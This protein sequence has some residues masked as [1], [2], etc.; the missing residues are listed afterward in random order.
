MK[1]FNLMFLM[2]IFVVLVLGGVVGTSVAQEQQNNVIDLSNIDNPIGKINGQNPDAFSAQAGTSI[3]SDFIEYDFDFGKT[4]ITLYCNG[5]KQDNLYAHYNESTGKIDFGATLDWLDENEKTNCYYELESTDDL[6][7]LI[8]IRDRNYNETLILQLAENPELNISLPE[9]DEFEYP[10]YYNYE[11]LVGGGEKRHLYSLEGICDK[12]YS[13]CSW[14]RVN[15]KMTRI[16]FTTERN[17]E[18]KS[19][20][21]VSGC[22]TISVAGSYQQNASYSGF[23]SDCIVIATDNVNFSG[24]GYTMVSTVSAADGIRVNTD[25]DN[26]NITNVDI[27]LATNAY[28]VWKYSGSN[29]TITNSYLH[30]LSRGIRSYGVNDRIDNV[31]TYQTYG[32]GYQTSTGHSN[33]YVTNSEFNSCYTLYCMYFAQGDYT[34]SRFENITMD[35][36]S[37]TATMFLTNYMGGSNF[38][39]IHVT[40]AYNDILYTRDGTTSAPPS[41]NFYDSSFSRHSTGYAT[42]DEDVINGYDAAKRVNLALY[43]TTGINPDR[44]NVYANDV[45]N[46]Y[47]EYQ[48][49]VNDTNGNPIENE[50]VSIYVYNQTVG[51]GL[52]TN[53]YLNT[54]ITSW[55]TDTVDWS[56]WGPLGYNSV[57]HYDID[58]TGDSIPGTLQ[59]DPAVDV[60]VGQPYLI[61]LNNSEFSEAS[62]SDY[63]MNLSLGNYNAHRYNEGLGRYYNDTYIALPTNTDNLKFNASTGTFNDWIELAYVEVYNVTTSLYTTATT[64]ASGGISIYLPSVYMKGTDR[65]FFNQYYGNL[66][67]GAEF[68]SSINVKD[69]LFVSDNFEIAADITIPLI[70][71]ESGTTASGTTGENLIVANITASDVSRGIKNITANIYN[72]SGLYSS[73]TNA[74]ISLIYTF[75]SLPEGTYYLNA[76]TYDYGFNSNSTETRTIVIT[77][78]D[79]G[80]ELISPSASFNISQNKFFNVTVNVSCSVMNCS[81]INVSLDRSTS[82]GTDYQEVTY[83]YV[84]GNLQFYADQWEGGAN[85]GEFDITCTG[86]DSNCSFTDLNGLHSTTEINNGIACNDAATGTGFLMYTATSVHTRFSANPPHA[87]NADN[88]ICVRYSGGWQYDSNTDWHSFTPVSTDTL[89]AD[90]SYTSDTITAK[91]DYVVGLV[92]TPIPLSTGDPFYTNESNPRNISLNKDESEVVTFWVNA[93]GSEAEYANL[94]VQVNKTTNQGIGNLTSFWDV[95][96]DANPPAISNIAF[97]PNLSDDIDPGTKVT[98]NVTLTDS[99]TLVNTAILQYHNGTGWNNET[100]V[101]IGSNIYQANITTVSIDANYTFN[102][103]ANDS[104]NNFNNSINQ[105]FNSTWDCTWSITSAGLT[106]SDA[107]GSFEDKVIGNITINNTGDVEY[108]D[109]N[110]SVSFDADGYVGFSGSY[111]ASTTWPSSLT[112]MQFYP[113]SPIVIAAGG[114]QIMIVNASFP[115]VSTPLE[116]TVTI[117]VVGDITDSV[118]LY[119][120]RT[121][122]VEMTV[123]KAGPYL[124]QSL[125]TSSQTVYLTN[126]TLALNSSLVN[127]GGDSTSNNSAYNASYDWNLPSDFLTSN[128]SELFFTNISNNSKIYSAIDVDF[129]SANLPSLSS[130]IYSINLSSNA[131]NLSGDLIVHAGNLTTLSDS[132]NITLLC[133]EPSDGIYVADCGTIDGDYA[134][135]TTGGSSGGGGGGGGSEDPREFSAA[136]FELLRGEEQK[137]VLTLENKLNTSRTDVEISVS[138]ANSQY[139]KILTP[140]IDEIKPFSS[141]DVIV[142]ITAPA[143]FTKGEYTLN[144]DI[145]GKIGLGKNFNER[146]KVTLF[147]VEVERNIADE[148][149]NNSVLFL[150]EMNKSELILEDIQELFAEMQLFYEDYNFIEVENTYEKLKQIYDSAIE[151][152]RLIED[153][154]SEIELAERN[155]VDVIETKK[156]LYTAET[157]FNRGDYVLALERL[158]EAQLTYALET[159]GEF[160][161]LYAVKNNPLQSLATLAGALIFSFGASLGIR[162]RLYK[163]KLKILTEEEKLLLELMKVVQRENFEKGKMSMEEYGQ[164]MTQYEKRLAAVI[165]GKINT[166]TKLTNLLKIKGKGKALDEEKK[167]L[168]NLIKHIQDKYLN[169]GTLETRVYE[170]TLKSYATRLS[171]VEEEITF[172]EANAAIKGKGFL[173]KRLSR[174]KKIRIRKLK[175]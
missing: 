168:I 11:G 29:F 115:D 90:I 6:I 60:I 27:D 110:C 9:E 43:N 117:T 2:G 149:M 34:N 104:V 172:N 25:N 76:T 66:S 147:I 162:H 121:A 106:G 105:T 16:D 131:Y 61:V 42:T 31:T 129:N 142:E 5:E 8:K 57:W 166:E 123:A 143:Y 35:S 113:E 122:S 92:H 89:V 138:G 155:G 153:L 24:N 46:W 154:N 69:N 19:I 118:N 174:N 80:L 33:A 135:P 98:F 55:T 124:R 94:S 140:K 82:G 152:L 109:N 28:G 45:I 36:S 119:D 68:N 141:E 103:W 3:N 146:K 53:P 83:G 120:N 150:E 59:P 44:V 7:E 50:N 167:R 151:G 38:T 4:N 67:S 175:K 39:N 30:S 93:T 62:Q 130:G 132:I 52:V 159:K 100:M 163:R 169:K 56:Y 79:V 49:Y 12:E 14:D 139:V 54:S 13:S 86:G 40:N 144:F 97:S 112:G 84:S 78:P 63:E 21:N 102:V 58:W 1:K 133:Y 137:F 81:E 77:Y 160:N 15:E 171:E 170:N 134:V 72:S 17:I 70:D 107:Y 126:Q 75:S 47:T 101:D 158:K 26:T 22:Q 87:D 65:T 145:S 71:F 48:G 88:Y 114:G 156:L 73:S 20:T 64:N 85:D 108:S 161:V 95:G 148:Y 32:V 165:E 91:D 125:I 157:A 173:R 37:G 10:S 99:Y 18:T 51:D 74:S 96:I 127:L 111:W 116:E 128:T 41:I 23:S 136:F 164:A